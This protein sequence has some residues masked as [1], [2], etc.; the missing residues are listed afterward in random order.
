MNKYTI[1]ITTPGQMVMRG[2]RKF[3]T[4]VVFDNVLESELP[5]FKSQVRQR[6][7]KMDISLAKEKP[8]HEIIIEDIDLD[9]EDEDIEIEPLEEKEPTTILEKL[10]SNE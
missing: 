8:E 7:L 2:A 10:L 5:L 9:K 1:K 6:M 3:R 4:P